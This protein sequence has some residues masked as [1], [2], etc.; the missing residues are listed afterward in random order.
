MPH[1]LFHY[2]RWEQKTPFVILLFS[3]IVAGV[4]HCTFDALLGRL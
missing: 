2:S 4:Y 3:A 1:W